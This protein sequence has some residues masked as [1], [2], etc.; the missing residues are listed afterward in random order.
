MKYSLFAYKMNHIEEIEWKITRVKLNKRHRGRQGTA[1]Q[2]A[3]NGVLSRDAWDSCTNLLSPFLA[4]FCLFSLV[5]LSPISHIHITHTHM[6]R[7]PVPRKQQIKFDA[8]TTRPPHANVSPPHDVHEN[9]S[10]HSRLLLANKDSD[11]VR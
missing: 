4:K 9:A 8:P 2:R 7:F 10:A 6:L 11:S 1:Q 5:F 3:N